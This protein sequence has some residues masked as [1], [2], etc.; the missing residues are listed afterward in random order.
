MLSIVCIQL[1][2]FMYSEGLN[3][4]IWSIDGTLTGTIT[5]GQ[6]GLGSNCNER[7]LHI[8]QS[9]RTVPSISDDLMSYVGDGGGSC[10]S[11][12]GKSVYYAIPADSGD[13][14]N[15][16]TSLHEQDMLQD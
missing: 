5:P 6:S 7:V 3:S 9:P 10:F 12:D 2:G 1:N 14:C 15:Y 4:S 11:I 13:V 8:L 16:Q